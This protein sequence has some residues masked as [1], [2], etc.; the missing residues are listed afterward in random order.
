MKKGMK[1]RVLA[2]VMVL[3][4]VLV[5][6]NVKVF[7]ADDVKID[8]F[9]LHHYSKTDEHR[10]ESLSLTYYA[11]TNYLYVDSISGSASA[12]TVTLSGSNVSMK[13]VSATRAS[14]T[15]FSY[16][17]SGTLKKA[18]FGV[19]LTYSPEN[20]TAIANGNIHFN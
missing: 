12:V 6:S 2:F 4:C 18:Q 9:N 16:A 5:G 20:Q 1:N 19:N 17:S 14:T 13:N 10:Y 15:P 8:Y 3:S 11:G 7:A